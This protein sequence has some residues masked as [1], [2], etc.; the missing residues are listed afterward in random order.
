MAVP[1][2]I[3]AW[4]ELPFFKPD[5]DGKTAW[6]RLLSRLESETQSGRH[7]HPKPERMFLALEAVDRANAHL[8]ILGQ[9]PYPRA[10][11]ATGLAF[12]LPPD[13]NPRDSLK[14]ILKVLESDTG[15]CLLNGDLTNW[16]K[17]GV[18]LFNTALTVRSGKAKS[19]SNFGW[20]RLAKEVLKAKLD[21]GNCYFL[22]LGKEAICIGDQIG[23]P[24]SRAFTSSHPSPYTAR[25]RYKDHKAFI[26]SKPFSAANNWLEAKDIAR[27]NWG[28]Q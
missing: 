27:I 3:G 21:D 19:H 2:N 7:W 8:I 4:K 5:Q 1:E 20:R 16:S 18:L 22:L 23:I 15:I 6:D 11:S 24:A 26:G 17:Q 25:K 28:N 10:K 14:N 9:D 13:E 12:S